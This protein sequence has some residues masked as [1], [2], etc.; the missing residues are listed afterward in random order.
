MNSDFHI[1][2]GFVIGDYSW[3]GTL[4]TIDDHLLTVCKMSVLFDLVCLVVFGMWLYERATDK[5]P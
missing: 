3:L 1:Y 5:I 2:A 4:R